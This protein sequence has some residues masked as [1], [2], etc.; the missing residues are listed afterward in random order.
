MMKEVHNIRPIQEEDI[1]AVVE[2]VR[3]AFDSN[4]LIPSIYRCK[5]IRN[6]ISSEIN[7]VFSPYRY[8]VYCVGEEIAGYA[9]YKILKSSGVAF[10]NI[11][12]VNNKY[13]NKGIGGILFK[14]TRDFFI[15]E[16]FCSIHLDVYETNFVA[17]NWYTGFGFKK[18]SFNYFY[19]VGIDSENQKP[20]EFFVQNFAQYK[21]VNDVFGFY[22][23][24]ISNASEDIRL[25]TIDGDL[26]IRGNYTQSL[27]I[28]LDDFTKKIS[29]RKLYYLGSECNFSECEFIDKIIRMELNIKL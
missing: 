6:F 27:R 10:L 3:E 15:K 9:E 22:F 25:G 14:H 11:I 5:G 28:Q 24:D 4:Y 17:L 29:F 21:V 20:F 7:N 12:A 16:G 23:L 18:T 13:K 2:V 19:K 26:F 1:D 8:F